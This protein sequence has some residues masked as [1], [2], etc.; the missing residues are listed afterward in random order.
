MEFSYGFQAQFFPENRTHP[1]IFISGFR[2]F[3]GTIAK[4]AISLLIW[5]DLPIF[6]K[7]VKIFDKRGFK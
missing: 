3:L 7:I 4:I 1:R 5:H 6:E 2:M